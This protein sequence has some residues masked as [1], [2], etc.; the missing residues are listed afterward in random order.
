MEKL[1]LKNIVGYLPYGLKIL[2]GWGDIT[3]LTC[4]YLDDDN[5]GVFFNIKP[6]L[7]PLSDLTKEIEVNGEKFVPIEELFTLAFGS[8][9][10]VNVKDFIGIVSC[11]NCI[12]KLTLNIEYM[13]FKTDAITPDGEGDWN[14]PFNQLQLFNKLYE[15]H[16]DI[17]G[18]I[19]T[20]AININTLDNGIQ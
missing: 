5:N 20:W 17:H 14:P 8:H 9:S 12:E 4:F 15:W 13:C 7:R 16:F 11:E 19:G 3:T 10:E 2:N 6:I 18:G 1:E